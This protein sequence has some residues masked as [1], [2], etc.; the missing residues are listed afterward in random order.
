MIEAWLTGFARGVAAAELRSTEACAFVRYLERY[1][2]GVGRVVE[3]RE[4]EH[5][6]LAV[7][8][9]QTGR[10][11]NS[12]V[13]IETVERIGI[14]F[15][16]DALGM[17][18]VRPLRAN[19]P[20]TGHQHLSLPDRPP[21]ICIDERAWSEARLTWG[22]PDLLGYILNWFRRAAEG[23][24]HDTAQPIDPNL[25]TSGVRILVP[26]R[27][28]DRKDREPLIGL[29]KGD[30]GDLEIIGVEDVREGGVLGG[31]FS[32]LLVTVPPEAMTRLRFAP[33]TLS[34]LADFLAERGVD[35]PAL[36]A[37]AFLA[38]LDTSPLY[39][40][41]LV[42]GGLLV[43][44]QMSITSGGAT[45]VQTIAFLAD[46]SLGQVAVDLGVAHACEPDPKNP[47]LVNV[48][49]A[50]G[51]T[52]LKAS[53]L[54]G[55]RLLPCDVHL[56]MDRIAAS[57]FAGTPAQDARR[58]VLVGAGAIG[59]HLATCL[60]REGRYLWTIIDPDVISPHNVARHVAGHTAVFRNKAEVLAEHLSDILDECDVATAIPYD[61]TSSDEGHDAIDAVL[62][63]A[64]L[65]ID[66]TASLAAARYL[67][68]HASSAR[69]LSAFFNPAGTAVVVLAEPADRSVTLRDL[70]AQFLQ[71][72]ARTAS[73]EGHYGTESDRIAYSGG[74][75]AVTSVF[76]QSR[77]A[78]LSG[79][80]AI[81]IAQAAEREVGDIRVWSMSIGGAVDCHAYVPTV[82]TEVEIGGWTVSLDA[83]VL[84]RI[85]ALRASALP[86]ETGGV[87]TGMVDIPA[88][89]LHVLHA[90]SPPA[91]SVH[92]PAGFVRGTD[93]V[94]AHLDRV[95][96]RTMSQV[97][98][99]G[100]WHS[101]P[102]G[103]G[104]RPSAVDLEQL[105][106]LSATLGMEE[107]PGLMTI[108]GGYSITI[109]FGPHTATIPLPH[110]KT[111]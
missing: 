60:A 88:K 34:D 111:A 85:V 74:C 21:A 25:I 40:K 64:D 106:W 109:A 105:D 87:L 24:L 79:S 53:V 72:V 108:I 62:A 4:G 22:P 55:A 80:A 92:A 93:G 6:S 27:L 12:A 46:R 78:V 89:R 51:A 101:H 36:L 59:S 10:P 100:E 3:T 70:E 61:V 50:I 15:P 52:P 19:F 38:A 96:D 41:P 76:P 103:S 77:V 54:A 58:V 86:D 5:S 99:L 31:M 47:E 73:L 9:L 65:I 75:G 81:G 28:L 33:G 83:I 107:L 43:L 23:E 37:E 42:D 39:R 57:R 67:S 84:K 66:A 8:D 63:E 20:V 14:E 98:Y 68:D 110:G 32:P 90:A 1:G 48:V 69:R 94:E 44:V 49:R 29:T 91:D 2:E 16:H 82:P 18:M 95:R 102:D 11:Q 17:P 30:G 56:A 13:E 97:R 71:N 104:T 45:N 35:L 7:F 26:R